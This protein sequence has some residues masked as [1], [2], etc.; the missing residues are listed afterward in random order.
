[1]DGGKLRETEGNW[2]D[3]TPAIIEANTSAGIWWAGGEGWGGGD[4]KDKIASWE[5]TNA[6]VIS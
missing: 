5:E 4:R 2:G 3:L 6:M 1:M